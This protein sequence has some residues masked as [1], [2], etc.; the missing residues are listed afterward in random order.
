MFRPSL[1][2]SRPLP[3]LKAGRNDWYK[4]KNVV[5]GNTEIYIYDEIG[6]FGITA[7]DFVSELVNVTSDNID[8]HLNTPGGDVF[9]GVAIYQALKDHPATV[10]TYVDALAASAGSFIAQAGDKVV[11]KK[12]AQMMIH[13]A[14]GLAIG[15]SEDMRNLADLLDKSSNNIASIYAERAGGSTEEWRTAM[16]AETWYTAEEAVSAGLADEVAGGS[17]DS[18]SKNSWDLSIYNYSGRDKAPEPK[19]VEKEELPD[20]DVFVRALKE[21]TA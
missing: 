6:Y 3:E 17:D 21:A 12:N 11:M 10:T 9:D 1:K 19:I 13:D 14:H 20:L 4:I 7:A 16:R 8:L 5:D 2:T 15:N 18:K